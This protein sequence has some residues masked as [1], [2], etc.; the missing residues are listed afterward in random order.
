MVIVT[1]E[2]VE[3]AK[4]ADKDLKMELAI[5]LYSSHVFNLRK[6]A[7]YVG[8]SWLKLTDEANKRALPCWDSI[9]PEDLRQEL[10]T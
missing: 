4:R 3:E 6:A 1:D 7:E 10:A 5:A 9:T 2:M 8:V